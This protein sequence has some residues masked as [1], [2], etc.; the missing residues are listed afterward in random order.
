M[1]HNWMM[2][3]DWRDECKN[4]GLDK[5]FFKAIEFVIIDPDEVVQNMKELLNDLVQYE[6]VAF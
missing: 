5:R 3:Q 4:V 6:V 1:W 2:D